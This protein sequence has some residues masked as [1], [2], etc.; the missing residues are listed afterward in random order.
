MAIAPATTQLIADVLA[1]GEEVSADKIKSL[2]RLGLIRQMERPGRGRGL[3]RPLGGYEDGAAETVAAVR[4]IERTRKGV[5]RADLPLWLFVEGDAVDLD[6]VRST[7]DRRHAVSQRGMPDLTDSDAVAER[8]AESRETNGQGNLGRLVRALDGSG[9]LTADNPLHALIE[10]IQLSQ[11]GFPISDQG[12]A[13]AS[14]FFMW[15]QVF[16]PADLGMMLSEYQHWRAPEYLAGLSDLELI[17]TRDQ[18]LAS[19]RKLAETPHEN[20][21]PELQNP[22][23]AIRP[24]LAQHGAF[25][26][27][28]I[29]VMFA[30]FADLREQIFGTAEPSNDHPENPG[31][32]GHNT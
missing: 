3:G 1:L 32:N 2:R 9:K 23:D 10:E 6:L 30:N 13:K 8:A 25:D 5:H 29:I 20:I 4:R 18:W 7:F 24:W 16:D 21:D 26:D 17:E 11:F 27:M 15:D 31:T 14:K 12:I 22:V 19:K 28:M